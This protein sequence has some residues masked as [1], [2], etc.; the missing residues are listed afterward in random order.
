MRVTL[1]P[2][3]VKIVLRNSAVNEKSLKCRGPPSARLPLSAANFH[4][5]LVN[6][7]TRI[8]RTR[9]AADIFRGY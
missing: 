5:K 7:Y 9:I 1:F 4:N 8:A 6:A 3:T 2:R